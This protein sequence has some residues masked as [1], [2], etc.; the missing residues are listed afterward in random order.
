MLATPHPF[1]TIESAQEFIVL[2]EASIDEAMNELREQ[3]EEALA[4]GV[5]RRVEATTLAQYKM[6][7]LASHIGKSRRLLNDLRT[8][9]RL[10]WEERAERA[11]VGAGSIV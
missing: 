5:A 2:L 6:K 8:L 11:G 10:L 9:R 4:T 7:Q 1:E 3:H